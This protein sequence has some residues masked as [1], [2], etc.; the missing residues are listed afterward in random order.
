MKRQKLTCATRGLILQLSILL[1][2]FGAVL[3]MPAEYE[4][5]KKIPVKEPSSDSNNG[6]KVYFDV[7]H[8]STAGAAD[9]V[10]DGGFSDFADALVKEGF[11]AIEY[12]GVDKNNDG[13]FSYYDDRNPENVEKNEWIITYEAIKDADVFVLAESNRPFRQDEYEALKTFVNSGKGIYF[14]S[15]HYNADRNMNTWDSTETF[16][17]YN[18][19]INDQYNM[20]APYGD[21][22]NPRD[23]KKGWLSEYFGLRFRFNAIDLKS[24]ASDIRPVKESEGIT[25]GVAPIL[26]AAGSTLAIVDGSKAKGIVYLSGS[27]HPSRWNN[28][29][30]K[31]L[32]YGGMDEGPFVAISKPSKGKAAFIGD[33]SPI[34]DES[35]KYRREDGTAKRTHP[36]WT[37]KGNAATLSINI[38]KWLATPED[39]VAFDGTLHTRGIETPVPMNESEKVQLG[40]EPWK[41]PNGFDPWDTS[42]YKSGCYGSPYPAGSSG[43]GSPGGKP[44]DDNNDNSGQLAIILAPDCI[45]FNHPFALVITTTVNNPELGTYLRDGGQQVGQVLQENGSWSEKGYAKLEGTGTIA[46]T[47]KAVK[48]GKSMVIKIRSGKKT[49]AKK[50]VNGISSDCE[51]IEKTVEADPGDIL[52]AEKDGQILGTTWI[53]ENKKAVIAVKSTDGIQWVIYSKEGKRKK[54]SQ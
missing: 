30:D 7:T 9:W 49:S 44:V 18:R 41:N 2:V 16:N 33:S 23:A 27:D 37:S 19:S 12:R 10:I 5:N 35:V 47:A 15:D 29:V 42:T 53:N 21:M 17:G 48:L 34:E 22:R 32:Y 43:A 45:Y 50:D 13:I 8:M 1:F 31:G 38:V 51:V 14:I 20:G 25:E 11:T 24:G 6:K 40:K 52:A 26:I 54:L 36:G 28:A 46:V 39:Y 3:L 4:W